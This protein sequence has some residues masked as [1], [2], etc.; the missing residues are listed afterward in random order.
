MP[1]SMA[2]ATSSTLFFMR[3]RVLAT[4][5]VLAVRVT[6]HGGGTKK[7]LR[8][9]SPDLEAKLAGERSPR[10]WGLF[11][12]QNMVD[13]MRVSSTEDHHTVELII[14]LG[15]KDDASSTL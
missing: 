8:S 7:C 5:E 14:K 11:L 3:I 6:D 10:G 2:T 13:E 12:I 1:W 4:D 9:Q 15:G